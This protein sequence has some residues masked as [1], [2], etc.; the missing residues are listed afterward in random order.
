MAQAP[1]HHTGSQR[2]TKRLTF[3]S[4]FPLFLLTSTFP[5]VDA[6]R[7]QVLV[8]KAGLYHDFNFT[9]PHAGTQI[10]NSHCITD[11][12]LCNKELQLSVNP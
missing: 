8:L 4:L 1:A 6:D 3:S 11:V 7:L 9:F 5:P 2:G 12:C 10:T